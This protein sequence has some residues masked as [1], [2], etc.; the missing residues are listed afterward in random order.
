MRK[1]PD[2]TQ[3]AAKLLRAFFVDGERSPSLQGTLESNKEVECN[4]EHISLH[5][6]M[7]S[8]EQSFDKQEEE[9]AMYIFQEAVQQGGEEGGRAGG[10]E[11][12]RGR[13]RG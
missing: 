7:T 4:S 11:K 5:R 13:A 9:G 10:E 1:R 8:D 12:R 2:P 3:G 6:S